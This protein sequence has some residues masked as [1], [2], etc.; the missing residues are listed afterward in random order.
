MPTS[1]P[2]KLNL[3]NSKIYFENK[4]KSNIFINECLVEKSIYKVDSS[5]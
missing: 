3:K 4:K 2:N 5:K 1:F